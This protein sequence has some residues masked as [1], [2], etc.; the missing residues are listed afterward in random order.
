M[1]ADEQLDGGVTAQAAVHQRIWNSI[2]V[3]SQV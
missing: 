2:V 3:F 1:S